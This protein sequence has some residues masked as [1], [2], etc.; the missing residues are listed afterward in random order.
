M[1]L[2]KT[3]A[4]ASAAL[5][6]GLTACT[7]GNNAPALTKSGLDPRNFQSEINGKP[8]ALY[9]LVNE[10][11][12]EVA[13]TNF[14]G[15][16]VSMMVPDRDGNFVDVVLGFDSVGAYRPEVNQSD[17]GASIGRYANRIDQG[18]FTLNDSTYQLP[19]N[20]FGHCLHGG[21]TGWQ[22][23]VY[24][25]EQTSDTTLV[26]T[27]H[28]PDGDNGFP[29]NID[30]TVTF[31]LKPDNALGIEYS[32]VTDAPTLINM[33]NHSYFNLTGDAGTVTDHI[34]TI[35]SDSFTPVDSTYMTTGEIRQVAGTAFDFSSPRKIADA[36]A[37]GADDEQVR[38]GNGFDHNWILNS[39]GDINTPAA[40]LTSPKTGITLTLYTTEPGVQA[41][42]GNFLDGT[43]TGKHGKVYNSRAAICL[44]PQHYPDSPNKPQWPS[45]VLEPGQKYSSESIIRFTVE[46]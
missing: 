6:L 27:M 43:L 36:L 21:P 8:T 9:T 16:I 4:C 18:R 32:A 40:I 34:L 3:T 37:A 25:A 11:G 38:N 42:S 12:M 29:G 28:S 22:Y 33:T 19:Q 14:G 39:A 5:L 13:I 2:T 30:A 15:R 7:T 46:D 45:T 17:F 24:D 41:Y 44:E 35:N 10:A 20:N 31:T 23:Q 26:L 1:K